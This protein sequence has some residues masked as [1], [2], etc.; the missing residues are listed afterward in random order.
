[1]NGT[2]GS[3]KSTLIGA[4]SA[5]ETVPH[6]VIDLDEIRRMSPAPT[7]DRFNHELELE[8]LGSV[9]ANY[10]RAGAQRFL[11]AGVIEDPAEVR[12]YV[13]ALGSSGMFI[14]RL[15]ARP[16]I[17]ESRLRHRHAGDP[18]A[19][20]WHLSRAGELAAIL[21]DVALD[22]LVLDSSDLPAAELALTVRRAAG[23]DQDGSA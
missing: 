20:Q 19:V 23:W 7:D 11:I 3:G 14:C 21:G 10:R 8:N 2:V 12:R 22:D 1:M 6:A 18:D 17:L 13:D 4:L 15:V 16:D 9:V 5:V